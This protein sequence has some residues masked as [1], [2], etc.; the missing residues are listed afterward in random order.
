LIKNLLTLFLPWS[1][2][3]I[4]RGGVAKQFKL[5]HQG[6]HTTLTEERMQSLNDLGFVWSSHGAIW[7]DRLEELQR[8]NETHGHCN[9]PKNYPDNKGLAVWVKC[10]RRQVRR[11][12]VDRLPSQIL[13]TN[14][15]HKFYESLYP[16]IMTS[17]S[18]F[19]EGC[20]AQ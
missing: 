19:K 9:V 8:Y 18:Y 1:F 13:S 17:T 15:N 12:V 14:H 5:R 20:K 2:S 16:T 6:K 10:Q 7:D 3:Y 4:N 11:P